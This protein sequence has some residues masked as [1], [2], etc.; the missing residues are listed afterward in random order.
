MKTI[1]R[2]LSL[3]LVCALITGALASCAETDPK[4]ADNTIEP[5]ADLAPTEPETTTE[6]TTEPEPTEPPTTKAPP[7]YEEVMKSTFEV[8][9]GN[10]KSNNQCKISVEDGVLKFTSTGDDPSIAT[11]KAFNLPTADI[12][13]IKVVLKNMSEND[14]FQIF[15]D[16]DLE[17]GYSESKSYKD[18][19][20]YTMSDPAG[21]EW[22][23][24]TIYTDECFDWDGEL[25]NMRID[26]INSEG[27]VHFLSIT[28]LKEIPAE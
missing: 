4:S 6:L 16:T 7:E 12:D 5:S 28:F 14:S 1:A 23:E 9:S 22:N 25:K 21:D 20:L 2:L 26:P 17:A 15:F 3:V 27:E 11:K 10:W 18:M 8:D 24:I 19:I 13:V